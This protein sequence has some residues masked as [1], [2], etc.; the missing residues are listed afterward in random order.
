MCCDVRNEQVLRVFEQF[1]RGE[2]RSPT[3][4]EKYLRDTAAFI[5]WLDGRPL[6]PTSAARWKTDLLDRGYAP[7]SVN[8]M[9][10]A[11]NKFLLF[12]GRPEYRARPLRLQP[13]LFREERLELTKA[14]YSRLLSAAKVRGRTRLVLALEAICATGIRVSELRCLTVEAVRRGWAEVRLKGKIRTILLPR[15]LCRKLARYAGK[16]KIAS[17]EIFLT[18]GGRSGAEQGLSPQPAAPVCP[19]L[20]P[21]LPRHHQAGG[22][23]G[24][25]QHQHHPDLF[26]LYRCGARAAAGLSGAGGPYGASDII[27]IMS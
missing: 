4:V 27:K 15:Q 13:R 7:V 10:A 12:L 2:E 14:E 11:V 17:G 26:A 16:Q 22:R 21:G 1:L 19:D 25:Q 18:R 9:L 5:C 23:T 24:P 8:S 20:L 6:A 3:T